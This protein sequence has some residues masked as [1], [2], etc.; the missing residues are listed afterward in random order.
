MEPLV[1]CAWLPRFPIQVEQERSPGFEGGVLALLTSDLQPIVAMPSREAEEA[2]IREKMPF[3]EAVA[4]AP[5]AIFRTADPLLYAEIF[6]G[7][8]GSLESISPVVEISEPGCAFL[9]LTGLLAG[10]F[11]S[12]NTAGKSAAGKIVVN[13]TGDRRLRAGIYRNP[14]QLVAALEG[15]VRLPWEAHFGVAPGKF[16]AWAAARAGQSGGPGSFF[17]PGGKTCW[18]PAGA[19][20]VFLQPLSV[21]LLP[22]SLEMGRRLW[23]VGIRTLGDV[24]ALP[25]PAMIAQFGKEGRRAWLLA[26]GQDED[27]V[28]PRKVPLVMTESLQFPSPEATL[29]GLALAARRLLERALHRPEHQGRAVKQVQLKA[30]LESGRTWAETITF[31]QPGTILA[32]LYPPIRYRLER[33][34]PE[35]GVEAL[36]L[37]IA[38]STTSFGGQGSLFREPQ[39]IR[40]ARIMDALRQVRIQMGCVP[41]SRIVE[42]EPWSRIPERRYQLLSYDP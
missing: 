4:M 32:R 39:E 14:R 5:R 15:A 13:D 23:K 25:L 7:I 28:Y 1:A 20:E 11:D 37:T 3:R 36:A 17:S 40:R 22:I 16:T 38:A 18:V 19:R 31:R 2:G 34:H 6:S 29:E 41:V 9:L 10:S 12:R 21:R 30:D 27:P 24:A 35:E 42:V 26:H 33:S 8:A